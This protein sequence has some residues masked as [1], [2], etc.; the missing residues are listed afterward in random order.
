MLFIVKHLAGHD[1]FWTK[2]LQNSSLSRKEVV[3]QFDGVKHNVAGKELGY[4]LE[5][6]TVLSCSA[7][8]LDHP[9]STFDLRYVL[10][11]A[12]QVDHLA[13]RH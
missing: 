7:F 2:V 10:I 12:C 3:E 13:T 4:A 8:L 1:C 9:D 5:R 11:A 6:K